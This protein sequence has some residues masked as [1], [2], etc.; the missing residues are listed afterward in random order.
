MKAFDFLD[1]LATS[2][3][4]KHTLNLIVNETPTFEYVVLCRDAN[5]AL[6][7]ETVLHVKAKGYLA[8]YNNYMVCNNKKIE[9]R[10]PPRI[11]LDGAEHEKFEKVNFRDFILFI[12]R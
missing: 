9:P 6:C 8:V 3:E 5:K 2:F 10:F 4:N 7:E 12:F 1:E 11:F